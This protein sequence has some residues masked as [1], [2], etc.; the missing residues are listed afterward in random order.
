MSV[1]SV[2]GFCIN[3]KLYEDSVDLVGTSKIDFS[4]IKYMTEDISNLGTSGTIKWPVYGHLEDVTM[5]VEWSAPSSNSLRLFEPR[6]HNLVIRGSLQQ[7]DTKDGTYAPKPCRVETQV[8]PVQTGIGNFE[9]GKKMETKSEFDVIAANM[10]LDGENIFH[11][12]K[13]NFIL[14]ANGVDYL[15]EVRKHIGLA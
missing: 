5:T 15:A 13:I 12:D 1:T 2:S 10:Y 9:V 11:F 14:V 8:I 4:D 7:W 3:G 6:S